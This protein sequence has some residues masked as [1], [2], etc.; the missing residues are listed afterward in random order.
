MPVSS[1]DIALCELVVAPAG[2]TAAETAT[3]TATRTA[4]RQT[5]VGAAGASSRPAAS[6]SIGRAKR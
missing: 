5:A 3:A 4:R 2:E 1:D 6:A